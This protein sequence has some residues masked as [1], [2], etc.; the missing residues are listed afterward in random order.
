MEGRILK[1]INEKYGQVS[2]MK[3]STPSSGQGPYSKVIFLVF[4]NIKPV[5]NSI[6]RVKN[7]A[8]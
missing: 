8:P 1:V 2:F 6:T 7:N 3:F 5:N 4:K